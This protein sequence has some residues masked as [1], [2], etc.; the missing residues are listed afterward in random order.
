AGQLVE[1][2]AA[3]RLGPTGGDDGPAV[4]PVRRPAPEG[5]VRPAGRRARGRRR[6][7][8]TLPM[9]DP[10]PASPP[11]LLRRL[12]LAAWGVACGALGRGGRGVRAGRG[13]GVPRR[14]RGA[15]APGAAPGVCGYPRTAAAAV[16]TSLPAMRRYRACRSRRLRFSPPPLWGRSRRSRGWGVG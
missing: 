2:D 8:R 11:D 6:V 9:T 10:A 16:G 5:P 12:A 1:G 7:T 15:H 4:R 14:L 3:R 13:V